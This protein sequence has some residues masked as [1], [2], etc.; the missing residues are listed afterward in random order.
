MNN[1]I[2]KF[3][4]IIRNHKNDLKKLEEYQLEIKNKII[5]SDIH[6]K[7]YSIYAA[8]DVAYR[9]NQ[10]YAGLIIYDFQDKT[11]IKK[12]SIMDSVNFPYISTFF[13]FREGP[14]ILKLLEKIDMTKIDVLLLNAHGLMHPRIGLA[15]HIG[16]LLDIPTIGI[17]TS[18]LT[19]L[20]EHEKLEKG[21]Y[22]NIFEGKKAIGIVF[23]SQEK[24]NPI[25]ISVGHKISLE[26][27]FNEV[28]KLIF[29][30]KLPL[31][32]FEAHKLATHLRNEMK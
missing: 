12:I 9:E 3:Y 21:D 5:D 19:G 27:A 17:A 32:L 1:R 4:E 10:G 31:P 20:Y 15:S 25:Y 6:L 2:K 28:K 24:M 18:Y 26:T 30:D 23:K 7:R 16:Y 29:D 22:H 11:I 14:I 8:I 13:S